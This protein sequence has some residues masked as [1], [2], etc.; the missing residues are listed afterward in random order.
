MQIQIPSIGNSSNL[1]IWPDFDDFENSGFGSL[2]V[3]GCKFQI[4]SI[5]NSSNLK[6]WPNFN[7]SVNSDFGNFRI[8]VSRILAIWLVFNYS[9]LTNFIFLQPEILEI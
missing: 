1:K 7:D 9:H 4:P 2:E 5:R 6:I 3:F 8:Q